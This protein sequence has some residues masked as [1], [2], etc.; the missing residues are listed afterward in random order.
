MQILKADCLITVVFVL[1]TEMSTFKGLPTKQN[2]SLTIS[3]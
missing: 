1:D 2:F 3:L